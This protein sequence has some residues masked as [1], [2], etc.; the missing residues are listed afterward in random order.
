MPK[1]KNKRELILRN[2]TYVYRENEMEISN[3]KCSYNTINSLICLKKNCILIVLYN[4]F[5]FDSTHENIN[6]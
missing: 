1:I 2:I 3:F 5:V 4:L 6:K